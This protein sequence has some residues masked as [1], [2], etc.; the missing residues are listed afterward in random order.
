MNLSSN[1]GRYYITK[2]VIAI[3]RYVFE[4]PLPILD[5]KMDILYCVQLAENIETIS[6]I[7]RFSHAFYKIYFHANDY[8][9]FKEGKPSPDL[10]NYW[11]RNEESC[12]IT[13]T[14]S[15][16]AATN[17]CIT[18]VTRIENDINNILVFCSTLKIFKKETIKNDRKSDNWYWTWMGKDKYFMNFNRQ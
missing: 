8:S 6:C 15:I 3:S 18:E 2:M 13:Q 10:M 9:T 5:I 7:Q 12:Q 14:P 16:E 17:K 4:W 1:T 11:I